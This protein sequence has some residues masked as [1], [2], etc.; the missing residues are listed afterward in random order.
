MEQIQG[1]VKELEFVVQSL[2]AHHQ[3]VK[4]EG[5]TGEATGVISEIRKKDGYFFGFTL[6]RAGM[7]QNMEA[8]VYME[9]KSDFAPVSY[10]LEDLITVTI[11]TPTE[12]ATL[13]CD[14]ADK[15][16][17]DAEDDRE[18]VAAYELYLISA[19][20]GNTD[21]ET[22]LGFCYYYGSGVKRNYRQAAK[23]LKKAVDKGD[24]IALCGLGRLY[25]EGCGVPENKKKGL[26]YLEV[27][28]R[29]GYASAQR[30]MGRCYLKGIGKKKDEKKAWKWFKRA[31]KHG[32]TVAERYMALCLYHGWG[33]DKNKDKA[34]ST[35]AKLQG[36]GD[37]KA[38]QYLKK[39]LKKESKHKK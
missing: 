4:V 39:W 28:A 34:I 5:K 30:E 11:P 16:A 26:T 17:L 15:V 2:Y 20:M 33:T 29:L 8:R 9:E 10:E 37:G 31:F 32:D 7:I 13:F 18:F 25:L 23:W 27:A 6:S 12:A 36:Q 24:V 21:A 14:M 38:E 22:R 1:Y 19:H 35:M 3:F